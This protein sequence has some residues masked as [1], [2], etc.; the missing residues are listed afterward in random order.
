ME[1]DTLSP[2][3]PELLKEM[4]ISYNPDKLSAVLSKRWPQVYGRAVQVR[5]GGTVPRGH[6]GERPPSRPTYRLHRQAKQY[7]LGRS[8]VQQLSTGA[9]G[10]VPAPTV[11]YGGDAAVGYSGSSSRTGNAGTTI[12][13]AVR[14]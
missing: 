3:M 6:A 14:G 2:D 8:G 5:A 11:P 1:L 4:G 13:Q 9:Y 7:V 10:I 12:W